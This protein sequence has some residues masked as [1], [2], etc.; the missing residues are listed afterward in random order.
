MTLRN[1]RKNEDPVL[2]K[3]SRAVTEINEKL[4][5]LV[6]DMKETMYAHNGQGLAAP[7]VGVLKRVI[8]VDVGT[9]WNVFLNPEILER[10]DKKKTCVEGCLSLPG[11]S[12]NVERPVSL[13]LQYMDLEGEMQENDFG[14]LMTRAIC[15]ETDHLNGVLIIDK[16]E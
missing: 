7:Q 13:K 10:S 9:G 3:K 6:E 16:I 4:L 8:A 12:V 1:I 5:T 14:K 15:H 11:K 2:R